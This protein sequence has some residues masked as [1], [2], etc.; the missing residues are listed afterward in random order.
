MNGITIPY[1]HEIMVNFD[2]SNAISKSWK[3]LFMSLQPVLQEDNRFTLNN[4]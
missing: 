3:P 4:K 2:S 1:L